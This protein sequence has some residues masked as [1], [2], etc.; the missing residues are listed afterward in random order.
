MPCSLRH[1]SS[2]TRTVRSF[3][4]WSFGFRF[5][6]EVIGAAG[7]GGSDIC[8]FAP[9]FW[10]AVLTNNAAKRILAFTGLEYC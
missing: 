9:W 8:A 4:V 10:K 5:G 2:L 6:T 3:V 1:W 7:S